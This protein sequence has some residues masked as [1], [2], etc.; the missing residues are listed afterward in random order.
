MFEEADLIHRY[1]RADAIRDGALIDVTA[2]AREAGFKNPVAL[3][4]A[5]WAK[6]VAVPAGVTCQ[7]EA[8]RLWNILWLLACA[9]RCSDGGPEVRFA[10]RVRN[11][12]PEGTPPPSLHPHQPRADVGRC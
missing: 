10:V 12:N 1:T 5:A 2:T 8:G 7:D 4:A 3:T 9:V 11:D 6:C